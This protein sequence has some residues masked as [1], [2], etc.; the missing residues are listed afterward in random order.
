VKSS[1]V[2]VADDHLRKLVAYTLSQGGY[3]VLT[4]TGAS[5]AH[6][7]A[8]SRPSSMVV[9][10]TG[11]KIDSHRLAVEIRRLEDGASSVPIL[12]LS[13][14]KG[15]AAPSVS[16]PHETLLIPFH[17]TK[18]MELVRRMLTG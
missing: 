16:G 3:E 10:V 17:P 13:D 4:A 2:V 14:R 9:A 12:M 18:L 1:I 8:S 11:P 15:A 5:D 6:A 7:Q